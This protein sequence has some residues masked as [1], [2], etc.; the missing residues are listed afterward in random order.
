MKLLV[1]LICLLAVSN[2][3]NTMEFDK[4]VHDFGAVSLSDGELSCR[5]TVRNTGTEPSA[6]YS[7]STN[8]RCTKI[9]WTRELIGPGKSGVI[10]VTY[11][12]DEGAKPFDKV[13]LVYMKDRNEAVQLHIRGVVTKK[14]KN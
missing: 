10:D 7:V 9:T 12:N 1:L 8:C 4:T 2:P 3:K 14:K 13:L 6:I 5:F 11:A